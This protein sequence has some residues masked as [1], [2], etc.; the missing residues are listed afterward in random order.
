M[1]GIIKKQILGF[2]SN[3]EVKNASSLIGE[4]IF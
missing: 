3:K 4:R 1:K 2:R